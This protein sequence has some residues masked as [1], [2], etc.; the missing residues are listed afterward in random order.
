VNI[1]SHTR[2]RRL[3]PTSIVSR[4]RKYYMVEKV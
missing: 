4:Y 3:I 2:T 1:A